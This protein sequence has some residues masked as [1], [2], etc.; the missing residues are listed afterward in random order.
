MKRGNADFVNNAPTNTARTE[1]DS[2]ITLHHANTRDS[3]AGRFLFLTAPDADHKQA[4]VFSH[5]PLLSFRGSHH[6]TQGLR[7][8]IHIYPAMFHGRI[9]HKLGTQNNPDRSGR[10]QW[11]RAQKNWAWQ[12]S[13][14]RSVSDA[15]KIYFFFFEARRNEPEV[16]HQ[17]L[18]GL[19]RQIKQLIVR[20]E[21]LRIQLWFALH[22]QRHLDKK[23]LTLLPDVNVLYS[24]G[25]RKPPL[26]V[27]IA[28]NHRAARVIFVVRHRS[29]RP[30]TTHRGQRPESSWH[31]INKNFPGW[32]PSIC[33]ISL[34]EL[35]VQ[36]RFPLHCN[37]KL[38]VQRSASVCM[39][40]L[41]HNLANDTVVESQ[42]N[43][44]LHCALEILRKFDHHLKALW[45]HVDKKHQGHRIHQWRFAVELG[46]KPAFSRVQSRVPRAMEPVRR[47]N[48]VVFFCLL[49]ALLFFSFC[50]ALPWT[51]SLAALMDCH[52]TWSPSSIPSS[53]AQ[54]SVGTGCHSTLTYNLVLVSHFKAMENFS[55][56]GDDVPSGS[57]TW[58]SWSSN[59][60]EK[61]P[62]K[63]GHLRSLGNRWT[64]SFRT[65][66]S[67]DSARKTIAHS[68]LPSSI[69]ETSINNLPLSFLTWTCFQW[70]VQPTSSHCTFLNEQF[71]TCAPRCQTLFNR[72]R[73]DASWSTSSW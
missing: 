66:R 39:D 55:I 53:I 56:D 54:Q 44:K 29:T 70:W 67:A 60:A 15:G 13:W 3:R 42:P 46:C 6:H 16:Q 72:D 52:H 28:L 2:V 23:S 17:F 30:A 5:L 68:M 9:S 25:W 41:K 63:W 61:M 27:P 58:R 12:E 40:G 11:P 4:Q 37:H 59:Q 22:H 20:A 18:D 10:T 64:H 71:G 31:H 34:V 65:P 32:P 43:N 50:F 7:Y 47:S 24:S 38:I 51:I 14:D 45:H 26:N 21:Q 19:G 73:H 69:R 49:L 48:H 33:D 8:T 36:V 57:S 1:L 35:K 62:L